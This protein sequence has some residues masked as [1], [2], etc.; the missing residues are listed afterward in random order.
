M[1]RTQE[2]LELAKE[3]GLN[4]W[5]F[6]KELSKQK[7]A[8]EVEKLTGMN[9]KV[10]TNTEIDKRLRR[11]VWHG[12]M[13]TFDMFWVPLF[14]GGFFCVLFAGISNS[15]FP[16]FLPGLFLVAYLF[17][18]FAKTV[19][20]SEHLSNWEGNLPYGALLA[21]KEAKANGISDFWISYPK[22][23]KKHT[24]VLADPI[25]YGHLNGVMI[26]VF[27]WDDGKIYE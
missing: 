5:Y 20:S 4:T 6:D 2:K 14:I 27:A 24:R 13:H 8:Q 16:L 22:Y 23:Q 19:V 21:V 17:S 25:I 3:L 9:F 1:N 18:C 26:E 10:I 15:I 7:V 12:W 11:I